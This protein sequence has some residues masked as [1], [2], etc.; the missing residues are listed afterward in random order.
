M[1][2]STGQPYTNRSNIQTELRV[3]PGLSRFVL[4]CIGF[5][6]CMVCIGVYGLCR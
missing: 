4:A 6:L 1:N 5:Y 3:L 2:I